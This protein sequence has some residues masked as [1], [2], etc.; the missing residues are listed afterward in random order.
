MNGIDWTGISLVIAAAGAF[1]TAAGATTVAVVVGLRTSKKVDAVMGEVVTLNESTIGELA[2]K[3]ET[4]LVLARKAA[5]YP[6]TAKQQRHLD[7]AFEQEG[8]E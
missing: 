3:N 1:V 8:S 7:A 4:L 6:L 5:G 2:A